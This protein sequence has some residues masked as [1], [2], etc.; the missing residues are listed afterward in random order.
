MK[1][2]RIA[3]STQKLTE[4]VDAALSRIERGVSY[5]VSIASVARDMLS[6]NSDGNVFAVAAGMK[7]A[8]L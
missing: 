2:L 1:A 6:N 7:L 8:L 4:W 5:F 3:G